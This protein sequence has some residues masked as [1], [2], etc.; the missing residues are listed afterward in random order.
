MADRVSPIIKSPSQCPGTP[1]APAPARRSVLGLGRPL[2][3]HDLGGDVTLRLIAR[4]LP[5]LAQRPPSP[6]AGDQLTLERAAPFDVERLVD[7]LVADAHVRIVG[8]V[9]DEAAAD[10]LRTPGRRPPTVRTM[11]LVQALPDRR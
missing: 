9:D 1:R 3:E 4:A 6:Q 2:G 5:G 7:R 11:G 10:L 8:E